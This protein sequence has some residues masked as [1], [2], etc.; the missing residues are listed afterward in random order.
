M[1]AS[2]SSVSSSSFV[3]SSHSYQQKQPQDKR[4]HTS[5]IVAVLNHHREMEEEVKM[6]NA[7]TYTA[8]LVKI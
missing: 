7:R 3:D 8:E 1:P 5:N 4:K 2:T 6:E